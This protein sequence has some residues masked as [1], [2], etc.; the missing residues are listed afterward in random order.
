MKKGIILAGGKGTRL[1][2]L[3]FSITKQLLPIYDKPMIY[4]PLSTMLE[5][6]V[7]DILI[8]TTKEDVVNF[9]KLF[10][11]G[12]GLGIRISYEIQNEPNGIAE[13][14]IIG[15]K[16]LNKNPCAFILG[17]N[18][19]IGKI[20][21]N[22]IKKSFVKQNGATIFTYK[23]HDPERYGVVCFNSKGQPCKIVEKPNRHLSEHAIT[24]LYL[25]DKN[26]SNIA[27]SIKPSKR[28]EL[29]ISDVNS[30]YLKNNL[31]R[32]IKLAPNVTWLDAGTVSSF[33]QASNFV[34]AL[35][36]RTGKKIGCIEEI[37]YENKYINLE[38]LKEIR[39]KYSNSKYGT[40][41]QNLIDKNSS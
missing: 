33:Y 8:I 38:K 37:S 6:G 19:F 25:F 2:P 39:M 24:G 26:A 14:L 18:L 29:E 32:V 17:D 36:K 15:E 11:N 28:N 5:L 30:F 35:E 23:V 10:G 41:L 22:D 31:L 27:K 21:N 34:G 1:F 3:T 7:K 13:A 40:Y 4:Y 9:Q 12:N 20:V 16:F